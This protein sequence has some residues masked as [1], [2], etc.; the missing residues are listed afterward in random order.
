MQNECANFFE[1]INGHKN[2][3]VWLDDQCEFFKGGD[4]CK[5]FEESILPDFKELENEYYGQPVEREENK[6][7][8]KRCGVEFIS[9]SNR[10]LYCDKCKKI[11]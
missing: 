4:K 7:L 6:K 2:F 10:Q 11:F 5:Y 8:C 9:K 3:C 1:E